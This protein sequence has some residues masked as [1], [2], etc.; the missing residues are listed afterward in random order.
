VAVLALDINDAGITAL[1]DDGI[2]YREPGFALV[3]EDGLTTGNEAYANA[4]IKPRRIHS[5]Y[6]SN[7][8]TD[9]LP[10]ERFRHLSAADLVSR[11]MEQLWAAARGRGDR[12]VVAVPHYMQPA[13]LSLFLGIC[14]D[15]GIPVA[16]LADAA[17]AAT[18]R[19]YLNATPVHVDVSLHAA[20]MTRIGQDGEAR[21]EKSEVVEGAGLSALQDAWI[22]T[23]AEAFVQQSR[24]DPLHTAETEQQLLDRLPRWLAATSSGDT[25]SASVEYRGIEHA[26]EIDAL[27][28]VSAAAPFY[29]QILS[30]LRTLC[31][32]D[33]T[34][35][36][37]LTDRAA[38]LPGLADLLKAR[39]GGEVFILE[40]GAAARGLLKRSRGSAAGEAGVSL[41]RKLPW[42]QSPIEVEVADDASDGRRPTHVLFRNTAYAINGQPLNLGSQSLPDERGIDFEDSMPG[43]S[44]KHCSLAVENG[45][46]VVRD[47]SRYGTF[48]NGHRLDGSAVLQTGDLIRI[49]TP[50]FELRLITTETGDGA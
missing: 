42:D 25:V 20:L 48:L 44:R 13:N 6:W 35:A 37:Q 4:R 39:I 18:R 32:A 41:V 14:A 10:D 50:G 1:D 47:Y 5:H 29:H 24:F 28:L 23:L 12:L 49:G 46:C 40:T 3:D 22:R 34:P 27:T 26:A 38:G 9:A 33:E 45:Q 16:M 8:T 43:V 36:V 17:V 7:L 31:R 2:V 19:Q 11:Q 21:S 30:R 15:L